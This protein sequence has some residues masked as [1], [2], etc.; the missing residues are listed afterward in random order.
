MKKT[1]IFFLGALI[2][3]VLL[4]P[5]I[6]QAQTFFLS[7]NKELSPEVSLI[8]R[9]ENE[10]IIKL[11]L[12]AY[13]LKKVK[14]RELSPKSYSIHSQECSRIL[15]KGAPG[16]PQFTQ[17]VIIPPGSEA[18]IQIVSSTYSEIEKIEIAPSKGSFSRSINPDNVPF[19]YGEE[20]EQNRFFPSAI[21]Q[22][23]NSYIFRDF[24]GQTIRFFPF[25]YNPVTK[26]LRIYKT[27]TVKVVFKNETKP[28]AYSKR[29][30][31][32]PVKDFESIYASHFL[33]YEN[34]TS[35]IRYSPVSEQGNLLIIAA[36]E[37]MDAMQDFVLWKRQKGIQTEMVDVTTI[38]DREAI[39]SFI[40]DYYYN[41]N[42]AYVLLVGDLEQVPS[43]IKSIPG[44]PEA[45]CDPAYGH[46]EGDDSYSEVI[47]GR[48]SAESIADVETQVRRSI[49]YEKNPP[50][51]TDW[52]R[53]FILIASEE[54]PGDDNE[55][56]YQHLQNIKTDLL[57]YTY[58]GGYELYEGAQ[59]DLDAPGDPTAG[60]LSDAMNNGC[61]IINYVG[62]GSNTSLSTTGFSISDAN[63]LLNVSKLPFVFDVACLN[64]NFATTCLA[65]KL[66]RVT[67]SEF[68]GNLPVG[69]VAVI[70][71][72]IEQ[73]WAPPMSGQD[74]MIDVLIES[75]EHNIKRTFGGITVN[76][77]MK[78]N[79]DYDATGQNMSDTW[80]IFGDPTLV[81]RTAEPQPLTITHS[82]VINI[83][84][85]QLS[86][87][88]NTENAQVCLS[89]GATILGTATVQDGVA[90]LAFSPVNEL[91]T[92]TL[93]VTAY[94]AIPYIADIEVIPVD[95]AFVIVDNF[96]ID[97]S[98]GNNNGKA[99]FGEQIKCNITFTNYGNSRA[100]NLTATLHSND[101]YIDIAQ[102]SLQIDSID[103]GQ[104]IT[105][106]AV[107]AVSVADFVPDLHT[108]VCDIEISE[109][110]DNVWH[111]PV[112]FPV[113]APQFE[114]NLLS[115]NDFDGNQNQ[116][117]DEGET[118]KLTVEVQNNGHAAASNVVCRFSANSLVVNILQTEKTLNTL[119]PGNAKQAVFTV[120]LDEEC[121]DGEMVILNFLATDGIYSNSIY[122][123]QRINLLVEDWETGDFE[124][125]DWEM[126]VKGWEISD[127]SYEGNY[128]AASSQIYDDE[129]AELSISMYVFDD[130]EI[131]FYRKVSSESGYDVLKFYI[132]DEL[133]KSWSG[134][135]DWQKV[136]FPV[137]M[138]KHT[139]KWL[140]KKDSGGS[141]GSDKAWIDNIVF[142]VFDASGNHVP[143]FTSNPPLIAE[144]HAIYTY[145][146]S[147]IDKD[148]TPLELVCDCPLW[149]GFSDLG[150]GN[151]IL[152]GT[153]PDTVKGIFPVEIQAFD[154]IA[155]AKQ[156]FP[157]A[158][159]QEIETWETGDFSA[160]NWQKA[161]LAKW[162]ISADDS[163]EGT[164]SAKSG[165]VYSDQST[166]L[167]ISFYVLQND[168]ISFYRKISSEEN[169]D[170]LKF[171]IDGEL[172][173]QWSGEKNW[174]RVAFPVS[175][176]EHTFEWVY[177][178]DEYV[179]DGMDCAWLDF[180]RFPEFDKTGNTLPGFTSVPITQ[181]NLN[182]EY[183]YQ[184]TVSDAEVNQSLQLLC[185]EKPAWLDFAMI[186][187]TTAKL[188]GTPG[189]EAIGENEVQLKLYD[190]I[191][192]VLQ[193]FKIMVNE[194][195]EDWEKGGFGSFDWETS[196]YYPWQVQQTETYNGGNAVKS[197]AN[198]NSASSVLS[199]EMNIA[200]AGTIS[201]YKKVSSESGYDFLQFFIDETKK[202]QWSGEIDWSKEEFPVTPG[203]HVFS[204]IYV[205]DHLE[206]AGEDCAWL[207]VIMLPDTV[208]SFQPSVITDAPASV[209]FH[210]PYSFN[211]NVF[212]D[213]P[214][215]S[216]SVT[217][218][219]TPE[220][221]SIQK[222]NETTFQFSG[223]P[224]PE[225]KG[226]EHII[227]TVKN[228]DSDSLVHLFMACGDIVEDWESNGFDDLW[229]DNDKD[230]AW[231]I[232][233][234][235][236]APGEFS[237]QSPTI[238]GGQTS[239]LTL[240][241]NVQE[242]DTLWFCRKVS[243]EPQGDF[244]RFY[245]DN[246]LQ[247]E[248][249]GEMNWAV[250]S[251]AI[252]RGLHELKWR[253]EK[254]DSN[255]AGFDAAWLDLL[256][257]PELDTS[258]VFISEPDTVITEGLEYNYLVDFKT[259]D[260]D[261]NPAINGKIIPAWLNLV[262][263]NDDKME[264]AG[265]PAS[266]DVG[267]HEVV[268]ELSNNDE[269]L[270]EQAFVIH[271]SPFT[272]I[273]GAEMPPN[274]VAIY[275]NP[276]NGQVRLYFA[277]AEKE[278]I[279]LHIFDMYGRRQKNIVKNV[280]YHK[281]TYIILCDFS[282][283]NAGVYFITLYNGAKTECLK[284][285][286][287]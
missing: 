185:I 262:S 45:L 35:N 179:N 220:W 168:T 277:S 143:E 33:N 11:T 27:I 52:Y 21:A 23:A 10:L 68:E 171:Y 3:S 224:L 275:P 261:K 238:A 137:P 200:E 246:E 73:D 212:D 227:F 287:Q 181:A 31:R 175:Y 211:V 228:K 269:V 80:T 165:A 40:G 218:D 13:Q 178:K 106:S 71:S 46:I 72:T 202:G 89:D 259:F 81:V 282:H 126:A 263:R 131:S 149:L 74:E 120:T 221:L 258:P 41:H 170:Y 266:S 77:C 156:A 164:Y 48:F 273:E 76:G 192:I 241:V 37:F 14:S 110:S 191:A 53:K 219:N 39:K 19:V 124:S 209:S 82:Q 84:A 55:Y 24:E 252:G 136:S 201:F 167:S 146:V 109:T 182:E 96:S 140:Y 67:S 214:C 215:S 254:N 91:K 260:S 8:S 274:N 42:I 284:V 113:H 102:N 54:G 251:Y 28:T 245:I 204:W 133:K 30:K 226:I 60:M 264:L 256:V 162:H 139:F 203:R 253:Y 123:R 122:S 49:E 114:L 58:N 239:A 286:K 268:L 205:K 103:A 119:S 66:L 159:G 271:V 32:V 186:N 155:F 16:L 243:S 213:S 276:T 108:V 9:S 92:L 51:E 223:T 70:A 111:T 278:E 12:N 188:S 101:N 118:I 270:A 50:A 6:S 281:G 29:A 99:D 130:D 247:G 158:V 153:P 193:S 234:G 127:N 26:K 117:F 34:V 190:G 25:Q 15:K 240:W 44:Y 184:I 85:S 176:G 232:Q 166:Q 183:E 121:E 283:H 47:I 189:C 125:Y 180:I 177:Q 231:I 172:K 169:Y 88:C 279:T 280:S 142:P 242:N 64:G 105:K 230:A 173:G 2:W 147:V 17:S 250:E 135:E 144:Y 128:S 235:D 157:L 187:D 199:L 43:Y 196:K 151:A 152:Q 257:L 65:E 145:H 59:G 57:N 161:G 78:M 22:T 4:F 198:V 94:N 160:Y 248:W 90:Q 93:T 62:H 208:P 36:P 206:S 112:Q 174:S 194:T 150:D 210:Q 69:A 129:K 244:L 138:G 265:V 86:V 1:Y 61:G 107:Y 249:S 116:R 272:G 115:V 195:F 5:N 104:S 216:L 97:D 75:Y 18:G 285:V 132:D 20:Y 237:A 87:N 63:N 225:N 217:F 134:E 148:D 233:S 98:E 267:E 207:D 255:T 222:E 236:F 154:G 83:G 56:D 100:E 229:W 7:D 197:G 95:G 38:G 141:S 163:F 79:D